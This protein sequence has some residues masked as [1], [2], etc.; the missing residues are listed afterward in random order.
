[1]KKFTEQEIANWRKYEKVRF[2]GRWNM[3]DPKAQHATGM[4]SAE[5]SFVLNNYD[6][7]K[8]AATEEIT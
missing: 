1:M 6:E 2:G 7:L 5:Y 3:F 4:D 8:T